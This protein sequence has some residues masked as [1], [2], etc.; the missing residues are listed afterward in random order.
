MPTTSGKLG[1]RMLMLYSQGGI[2]LFHKHFENK[3]R[4][5]LRAAPS[6]S[7]LPASH[8]R[9]QVAGKY[10]NSEVSRL[11]VSV[12]RLGNTDTNIHLQKVFRMKLPFHLHSPLTPPTWTPC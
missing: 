5:T 4:K 7:F 8:F 10:C 2:L 12:A 9:G 11:K 6:P 3:P 1:V